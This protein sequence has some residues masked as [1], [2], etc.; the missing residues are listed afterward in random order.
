MNEQKMRQIMTA[1]VAMITNKLT[2]LELA[3][4][5]KIAQS[6]IDPHSRA[7]DYDKVK[8]LFTVNNGTRMHEET[9]VALDVIVN[10]R[11]VK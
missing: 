3:I 8:T 4:L 9:K 10:R 5:N 7:L 11:L 6:D 1:S 2:D